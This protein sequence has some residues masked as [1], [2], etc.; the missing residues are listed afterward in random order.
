[1]ADTVNSKPDSFHDEGLGQKE[2]SIKLAKAQTDDHPIEDEQFKQTSRRIVR[3]LDFTLMPIIWLL[4]LFNYLDRT[5]IAQAK[6][7]GIEKDL[8]LTGA[9]FSTAVSILN[10]GYM[11]MQIPSNMILTRVRPSIYLPIWACVWS[12]VS[13]STAAAD[14]FG[15]LI[16]VRCLLGIAEAPFFP[17]VFFLLS[18]WYTRGELGLRMAI[19]YSGLVVATAFSGL[20]AAGVFSNLDQ[21]RGLAGWRWL[22]IIIGSVN[23]LLALCAVV[24]LPDFPESHTGS[25]KWLFTEEELRVANQRIAMDRI[26]QE[27]NRSVWWGFKRAVTDYRTWVFIFMLICNHAAYGFNYFY[28]SIVSGFGL[29]SRTITLLC[30][31]PPFLIGA[32]A[33]LFISWS[34]DKRNERSYHIAIPMGISVVG[35]VISVSTLNGPARYVASFL[36]VTG[37]FAA[38]GIVYSWAAGVLNQTPEKKAV[39]TSMINVIAQLGNIMS[40][41]FFRDQDEP[42]YL[43]AMILL[44][45]F[46]TLSGLTC[47]F[48]KWDLTRANKKILAEAEADGTE[49]R[50]FSH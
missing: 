21:V 50:L 12:A 17:G 45:V 35:F 10:V 2:P 49:P 31:A 32:I 19:L 33:S 44:I 39:A 36:Y 16:T 29:G 37:C 28:P 42:R 14:N 20:I 48:L 4:Y 7:N 38:N 41:Y 18:C 24:L 6:L 46:A 15:H 26:P 25:Q 47:L 9:Q 22:Y 40:P 34:S 27:S 8:N 43:M 13:A 11:V 3:K 1:M 5:A 30:T 23:F